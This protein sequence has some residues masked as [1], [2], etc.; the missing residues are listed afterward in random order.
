MFK[1]FFEFVFNLINA[2]CSVYATMIA[3][4]KS[5]SE[6]CKKIYSSK[7]QVFLNRNAMVSYLHEMFEKASGPNDLIWGQSM[8]GRHYNN[9]I[10]KIADAAE[11]GAKFKIIFNKNTAETNEIK[12]F[13]AT[14]KNAEIH[15]RND[16]RIRVMGLSDKEVVIALSDK[17]NYNAILIRD[18]EMIKIIRSWFDLRFNESTT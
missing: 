4:K 8:T 1:N 3:N 16:N 12:D 13:F 7:L 11:R 9:I 17:K 14:L 5:K 2:I 18:S 10:P 6:E 15:F